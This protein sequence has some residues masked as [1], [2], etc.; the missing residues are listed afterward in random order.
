MATT[1]ELITGLIA[2]Y[3]DLKTYLEGIRASIDA[4][5]AALTGTL[6]VS[7]YVDATYGDDTAV[8]SEAAPLLTMD[9]ALTR[10]PSGF[11]ASIFLKRT[12]TLETKVTTRARTVLIR[13]ADGVA[14]ALK[15][16]W[17]DGGDGFWYPGQIDFNGVAGAVLFN[18]L[19]VTFEARVGGTRGNAY[20]CGLVSTNS[21]T[22]KAFVGLAGS[23]IYRE[24]GADAFLV[25]S[26]SNSGDLNISAD[27]TYAANM[28]GFWFAGVTSGTATSATRYNTNLDTL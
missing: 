23:T 17:Y 25:A 11:H 14:P 8:G 3:T 5:V 10:I 19:T 13:P 22:P 16:G 2:G 1:T 9:E 26:S 6:N 12:A 15:I 18:E 28:D 21:L 7:Y 24:V 27:T 20:A 4:K